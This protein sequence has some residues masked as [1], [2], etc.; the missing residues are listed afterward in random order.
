MARRAK[1]NAKIVR[2][3]SV[4][5]SGGKSKRRQE[6]ERIA[7]ERASRQRF[8]TLRRRCSLAALALTTLFVV[9]CSVW[10][11]QQGIMQQAAEQMHR[12][13]V[14]TTAARGFVVKDIY[15]EGRESVPVNIVRQAAGL[16]QGDPLF[17]TSVADIKQRL[18][19]IPAIRTAQ[20]E[21]VLPS[22]VHIHIV[23]RHPVALWQHGGQLNLIDDNG[24]VMSGGDAARHGNLMLVVGEDA[25]EHAVELLTVMA[26]EKDLMRQVKAAVRVGGRRWNV[27]FANGVEVKLPERDLAAAWSRLSFMQQAQKMLERNVVAI[28]LRLSDRVYF[29][30][31]VSTPE[32]APGGKVAS[33]I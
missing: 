8:Q 2:A 6:C 32:M 17:A 1:A 30:L 26:S 20:V 4:R 28:D 13:I 21:R 22:T 31:P 27:R 33:A 5:A 19:T 14:R 18:E 7:R 9:G 12:G 24:V 25:P 10:G 3:E 16:H 11:W 29:K 23:E 15:L